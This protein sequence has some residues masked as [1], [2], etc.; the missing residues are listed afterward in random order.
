MND[1]Q[2]HLEIQR[3]TLEKGLKLLAKTVSRRK[4]E[5]AVLSFDGANIHIEVGG[6]SIA[7]AA[8]GTSNCQVRVSGRSIL[9]L[10]T[11]L[12][13]T[14]TIVMKLANGHLFINKLA[15]KCISQPQWSKILDLPVNL[16][17]PNAVAALLNESQEDI[18]A[19]GLGKMTG[20]LDDDLREAAKLLS[21]YGVLKSDLQKLIQTKLTEGTPD[22]FDHK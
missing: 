21:K 2:L 8:K 3:G 11:V 1:D 15:L 20:E 19:S 14:H 10:A 6:G 17:G 18:E 4:G 16:A 12:P 22:L 7:V 13:S 9:N 5:E